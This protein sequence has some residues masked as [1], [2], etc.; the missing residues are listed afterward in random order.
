MVVASAEV[1]SGMED[2]EGE[3]QLVGELDFL[4]ERLDG[5]IAVGRGGSGDVDEVTGVAEEMGEVRLE[6]GL[7]IAIELGW[8]VRAAEPLHV[9]F[10]EELDGFTAAMD[11]AFDG[12]MRTAGGGTMHAEAHEWGW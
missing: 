10:D 4:D 8:G 2:E 9:V 1:G 11:A 7:L 3:L 12:L 6:A 5:A